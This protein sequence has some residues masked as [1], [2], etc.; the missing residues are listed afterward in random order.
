M[1]NSKK[2]SDD[3]D[4]AMEKL[5]KYE[6]LYTAYAD[7]IRNLWQRSIFLGAFMTLAWG[8]Y[9][10]LQLKFITRKCGEFDMVAYCIASLGICATIMILSLLWIA[11]A[12]GS[13]FVQ[14]AHE[15][16]I[17]DFNFDKKDIKKLFCKLETYEYKTHQDDYND[18]DKK[19]INK[20][21]NPK[22]FFGGA[23][24]AYRYSP[25]KINIVLGWVS[26]C[27]AGAL[28]LIHILM[29]LFSAKLFYNLTTNI[30]IIIAIVCVA[31]EIITM[32]YVFCKKK[33]YLKGGN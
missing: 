14:E 10:A 29:L 21:L 9:G 28:M 32:F 3:E 17:K 5:K 31:V 13:K 24:K 30:L 8:G 16:H 6:I 23:L 20:D 15:A 19:E 22:L 7:E 2:I 26:A 18:K 12:K 11:M 25:S 33:D 27:L 1:C 4:K